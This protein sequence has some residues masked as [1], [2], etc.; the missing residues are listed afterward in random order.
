MNIP[1]QAAIPAI[2]E[3]KSSA[4]PDARVRGIKPSARIKK[5]P[6]E[7]SV[8]SLRSISKTYLIFSSKFILAL[9]CEYRFKQSVGGL[10]GLRVCLK[11]A[12][13]YNHVGKLLG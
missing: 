8:G 10:N 13:G 2:A 9:E 6:A 11:T 4:P 1:A 7:K 12:L 5:E 3:K